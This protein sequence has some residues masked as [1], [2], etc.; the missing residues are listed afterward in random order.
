[1]DKVT[2]TINGQ[3]TTV[4]ADYTVMQS[5]QELGIDIP[6]LCFLKDI[7]ETSACR[8][9]VVD[10]KNMRGLKNSCT[11]AVQDGM[12]VETNTE[13]IHESVVSNLQL[14]ASNHVFECWACEREN[15][16][17]LL[18]LMRRYNVENV[19]GESFDY[20]KKN[21][22]IN[23]SSDS[24]V[25]DSGKCILCGRCISACQ[26]HTELGV[27]DFN[28]RGN[29]TYVGPA[30]FHSMEDSG[31]ISCGKC[32]EACPVA[33]IKEK[34]AIDPV[35][36][37]LRNPNKV[38]IVAPDPSVAVTLG[39][40]FNL[41]IGSNVEGQLFTALNKLGFDEVMNLGLAEEI[42]MMEEGNELLNR[43][44][45]GS[46]LPL[47]TSNAPGW[48]NYVELYEEDSIE[49]LSTT[50]STGQ[51]AGALV[52]HY[53]AEQLGYTKEN[54]V[55]VSVM[56]HIDKK[57]DA[58]RQANKHQGIPDV[59]YVLTVRELGR[60][61]KRRG[62]DLTRLENG[63]PNG[64]LYG[65]TTPSTSLVGLSKLEATLHLASTLLEENPQELEF[66]AARGQAHIKES[67]YTLHGKKINVA[68]VE[69]EHTLKAFFEWIKKTK[70]D[71]HY[72]EY[73]APN[74]ANI[75]GGGQPIV[76]ADLQDSVNVNKL[77][78]E[79]LSALLSEKEYSNT[80]AQDL[81]NKVFIEAGSNMA[82]HVLHT[83]Y[84]ARKFYK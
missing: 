69:N 43:V 2:I 31:C 61:L 4:P 30:L 16:C 47:L 37:A 13:D 80:F 54:I 24:I 57:D 35:M 79:A 51:V 62:I 6:R 63:T 65:L 20:H 52:K 5:A 72:V 9:C 15:N 21:R 11:L 75:S 8:L 74:N 1:M 28:Q 33:A 7:N 64:T 81:Y 17:E 71:Y 49:Q 76:T 60:L 36:D 67:S 77:R 44:K 29:V 26:K 34:S 3:K 59:D 83:T 38:V 50:K 12:E 84:Q 46:N 48:Q 40:D 53:Y 70:K 19:Y 78:E 58:V 45:S 32:I 14:L 23:D 66:K 73:M 27:L 25:L 82:K 68:V 22:L 18:D 39:E 10:V 41:E 55:F 56:P 42:R